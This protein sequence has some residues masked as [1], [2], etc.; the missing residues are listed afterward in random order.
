MAQGV[1]RRENKPGVEFDR[2]WKW[3]LL[4]GVVAQWFLYTFPT[5][6][7][8]KVVTDTRVARSPIMTYVISGIFYILVLPLI[9][10][11]LLSLI[12]AR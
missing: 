6:S 11:A 10:L 2:A 4:P 12:S 7:F 5:G 8:A 9:G 3:L 1:W